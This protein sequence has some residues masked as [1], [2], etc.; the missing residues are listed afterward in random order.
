MATVMVLSR[1]R[2]IVLVESPGST[3]MTSLTRT[4]TGAVAGPAVAVAGGVG[5]GVRAVVVGRRNR[6]ERAG[7]A[8]R[9][10]T[11]R[12]A[13]DQ[14]RGQRVAVDVAVV[15]QHPLRGRDVQGRV[16]AHRVRVISGDG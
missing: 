13:A 9:E 1:F 3:S 2:S 16:L 4:V 11:V 14:R 7:R 8:E 10:R 6:D 12:R 5:E 15:G